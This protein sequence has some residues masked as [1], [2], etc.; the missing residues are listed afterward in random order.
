[1]QKKDVEQIK[2]STQSPYTVLVGD[3][4][5]LNELEAFLT[6]KKALII[7][8]SNL[9]GLYKE[10]LS[11]LIDTEDIFFFQAG[12]E[13]KNYKTLHSI[14]DFLIKKS[15]DRYTYLIGV[16]GGVV[17]DITAFAASTYMR[18]LPVVHA[19]TSLL[20]M[21]D[22]SIGGKTAINYGGLKNIIG[23]FYQPSLVL[24]DISFLH[25]LPDRE[26]I[27]ALSEII[28]YGIIMDENFFNFIDKN[29]INIKNK[30]DIYLKKLV[31][32]SAKNKIEIIEQDE[33]ESNIR[34]LLNLGHTMAHAI[35]S[36]TRYKRYLHGEAVSIG[37]IYALT[38]SEALGLLENNELN[39][40]KGLFS[41][42][43]LPISI[44]KEFD[45]RKLFKIIEKDKKNKNGIIRF[46]LTKKIGNSII[47]GNID[48]TTILEVIDELKG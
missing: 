47:E 27:S 33:K 6:D 1:M 26:F 11:N 12:E 18:G 10:T 46:V 42:F 23:N 32:K 13:S 16:G 40:V 34:A 20:A 2:V 24:S 21:A 15:A 19:P 22:S 30:K 25:T 31:S 43:K 44:P 38:L 37:I 36:I 4:I 17:G 29:R 5:F 35:E 14:Y 48:R 9:Y 45:S 7:T 39:R 28:K 41:F 8:D 3:N